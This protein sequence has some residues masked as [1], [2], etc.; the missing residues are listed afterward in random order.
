MKL[1]KGAAVS[2]LA[3]RL[4]TDHQA[5]QQSGQQR[6]CRAQLASNLGLVLLAEVDFQ[7]IGRCLPVDQMVAKLALLRELWG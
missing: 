1:I 7:S 6:Q 5:F 4:Q 3:S 2:D